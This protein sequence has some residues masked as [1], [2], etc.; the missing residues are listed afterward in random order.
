MVESGHSQPEGSRDASDVITFLALYYPYSR[1]L[2]ETDLKRMLL[3]FDQ[4]C[5][6]DPLSRDLAHWP[7]QYPV[8][9]QAMHIRIMQDSDRLREDPRGFGSHIPVHQRGIEKDFNLWDWFAIG[10]TYSYL[11]KQGVV[12]LLDPTPIVREHSE[13]LGSMLSNQTSSWEQA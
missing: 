10:D 11:A 5:F 4:I 1:C 8:Y 13:L 3:I 6:V 12:R 9:N 7:G 2:R